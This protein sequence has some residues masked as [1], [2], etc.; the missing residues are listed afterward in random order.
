M[1]KKFIGT[2]GKWFLGKGAKI[3]EGRWSGDPQ[4]LYYICHTGDS[5]WT[6]VTKEAID[7]LEATYTRAKPKATKK[8]AKAMLQ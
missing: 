4:D 1:A 6:D 5:Q 8:R 7:A 3:E 2:P